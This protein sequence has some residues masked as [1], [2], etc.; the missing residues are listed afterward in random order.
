VVEVWHDDLGWGALVAPDV[1]GGVWAHFSDIVAT[2]HRSL[3]EGDEVEFRWIPSPHE[4]DECGS[5][6]NTA[7]W[8]R[9]LTSPQG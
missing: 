5:W 9:P 7:T 6:P 2:G 4:D 1:P 8:V 3:T